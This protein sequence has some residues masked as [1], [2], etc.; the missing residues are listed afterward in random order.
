[1]V[2]ADVV[3]A[4]LAELAHR[5]ARVR[6]HNKATPELLAAAEDSLDLVSFNLMLAIQACV[7]IASH[8]VADEGWPLARTL[9]EGFDRLAEHGVISRESAS[10][11]RNASSFRNLIAHGYTNVDVAI[12]Q[13]AAAGGSLDI[14]RFARELASWVA[15]RVKG[16]P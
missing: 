12:V 11:M 10:A 7:D 6:A 3:A 5:L 8:I 15:A 4:K 2:D 16:A 9:G 14:D 1:M 13:R